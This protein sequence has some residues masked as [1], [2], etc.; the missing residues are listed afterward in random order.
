M[1]AVAE[2]LHQILE[3]RAQ[4]NAHDVGPGHHHVADPDIAERAYYRLASVHREQ[5]ALVE[6]LHAGSFYASQGPEILDVTPERG[7]KKL[8]VRTSP[9]RA[10]RLTGRGSSASV[11]MGTADITSAELDLARIKGPYARLTV[12]DKR[13]RRAWTNP[14]RV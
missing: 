7:G 6:A 9:V 8:S 10:M 3:A 4:I 13:G 11:V 5:D 1:Q 2:D 12:F 14:F